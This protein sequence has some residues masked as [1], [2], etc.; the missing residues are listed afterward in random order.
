M[1]V[2]IP[3]MTPM[4]PIFSGWV[5]VIGGA[6]NRPMPV[7]MRIVITIRP[8]IVVVINQLRGING[9]RWHEEWQRPQVDIETDGLRK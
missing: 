6:I 5:S 3:V 9:N 8:W 7:P 4:A 2:P 1:I